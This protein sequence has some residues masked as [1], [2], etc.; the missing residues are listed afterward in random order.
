MKS[1]ADEKHRHTVTLIFLFSVNVKQ[2]LA[3]G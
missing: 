3:L 2:V 1:Q